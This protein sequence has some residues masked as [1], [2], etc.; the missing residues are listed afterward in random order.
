MAASLDPLLLEPAQ[1]FILAGQESR[2]DRAP[3]DYRT[4]DAWCLWSVIDGT[5]D[6]RDATGRCRRLSA[7]LLLC[8]QPGS[9]EELSVP[10]GTAI[11]RLV[12]ALRWVPRQI[13]GTKT[14]RACTTVGERQPD[15]R[16]WF[17]RDLP[18]VVDPP[19]RTTGMRVVEHA[20]RDWWRG[21][22]RRLR[23]S[24]EVAA[25]LYDWVLSRD[26]G[27]TDSWSHL[28]GL[29]RERLAQGIGVAGLAAASGI[30]RTSLLRRLRASG[31]GT[32]SDWIDALRE[33]EAR[34]LLGAR[35][36]V[37]N[38][39]RLCGFRS[40][41]AFARWFRRR[42]GLPPSQVTRNRLR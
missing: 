6:L 1:V 37:R 39:A 34:R 16:A 15:A 27:G 38:V 31:R 42:C 8:L 26:V 5:V 24:A 21:D 18:T 19:F 29:V 35:D 17:G 36:T 33:E 13:L 41:A 11:Q 14:V 32:P 22:L 28:E 4:T 20:C 30:S 3:W 2:Y 10:I 9:G 23:A 12:L 40:P 7:P 25:W